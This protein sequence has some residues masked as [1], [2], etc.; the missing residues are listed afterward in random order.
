MVTLVDVVY[1]LSNTYKIPHG[2]Y[3]SIILAA[4]PFAVIVIYTRGEK[5]LYRSL[6]PLKLEH[7]LKKFNA[8]YR[9]MPK[10]KGT[11]LFFLR[12]VARIPPYIVKTL[13]THDII[14]EDNILVSVKVKDSPFGVAG[15]FEKDLAPGLRVYEINSGYMEVISVERLMKNAG[16][17]EKTIFYGLEDIASKNIVWKIFSL[18]KRINPTFIQFH[19]LPAP[20]LYGVV[21][22]VEL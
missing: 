8:A 1:F 15:H 3:W 6:R 18:I 9:S 21:T 13:F 19:K 7:F 12:D 11:A 20:K 22:R 17:D 14:Y 2:G 10:I 4:I 5:R 16:I